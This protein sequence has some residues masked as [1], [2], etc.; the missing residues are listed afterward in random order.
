MRVSVEVVWN[1]IATAMKLDNGDYVGE[2]SNKSEN[3]HAR[4]SQ[5]TNINHPL[6]LL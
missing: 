3:A 5:N 1:F 2:V 6:E 4:Q